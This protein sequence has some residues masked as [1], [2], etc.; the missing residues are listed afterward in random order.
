MLKVISPELK[1]GVKVRSQRTPRLDLEQRSD[2]FEGFWERPFRV[3]KSGCTPVKDRL[4]E[5]AWDSCRD[6]LVQGFLNQP[7]VL[8]RGFA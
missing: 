7:P 4:H 1:L 3:P 6:S 8:F 2:I 5:R